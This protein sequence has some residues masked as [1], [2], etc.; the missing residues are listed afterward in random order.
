MTIAVNVRFLLK[1]KL[2]GYGYFVNEIFAI[3]TKSY[4]QHTFIFVFDRPFD[5]SFVFNNSNIIPIVVAPK[6]R[7]ALS[8]F[9][10]Y[11][12]AVP[13]AL[14]KYSP[15]IIVQ[16]FGFCSLFTKTPQLLVL[17]D[18]AYKH[19]P[20]FIAKHHLLFYKL[21][22]NLFAKK[23]TRIATV[24][25]FSKQ[26]IQTFFKINSSKIDVVY[27]AAK[28]IFKPISN[29]EQA[30]IKEK[31]T[32]GDNYFLC[33]GG[34]HPRKNLYTVL[35]A[36]SKFKKWQLSNMKLVI[37]GRK[38]WQY[39]TFI[40]LLA[41]YKYKND[42]VLLDYV[43]ENDLAAITA[44]AYSAIYASLYEGFGVPILEAMQSG[45][46]VITSNV[47]SMPEVGGNCVL[48]CNPNSF[49][50]IAQQMID[51]YKDENLRKT[52]VANGLQHCQK[53]SWHNTSSLIW[54]SIVEAS[55]SQ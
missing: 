25:N 46:P 42:V 12:F 55:S 36:F 21:F 47:S 52:L 19:Y 45:V 39:E 37:V 1:N 13:F 51:I 23:A 7:F 44:S 43:N 50:S 2:E 54:Q 14:K 34:I 9:W 16:P 4:P 30:A 11:N 49:E 8:Y 41:T 24:S 29:D 28:L 18:L 48:Y 40:N 17:H 3:L 33:V 5:T 31:Y 20:N 27:S 6:A 15:N 53:Y 26:E 38:A 35:K 32:N 22:T 10:W